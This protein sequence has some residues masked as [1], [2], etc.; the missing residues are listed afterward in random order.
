[1]YI[2]GFAYPQG[3]M[4]YA[5]ALPSVWLL[6]Q[7][8]MPAGERALAAALARE[9]GGDAWDA[10]R[11]RVSF[12]T[13]HREA[14]RASANGERRALL[15]GYEALNPEWRAGH[16]LMMLAR[17]DLGA[18]PRLLGRLAARARQR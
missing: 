5:R 10:A 6:G 1:M 12:N 18:V 15:A 2:G 13:V 16:G 11:Q 17:L 9:W 4:V 8:S 14:P 7:E 3:Y